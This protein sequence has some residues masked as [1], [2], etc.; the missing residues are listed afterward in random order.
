MVNIQFKFLFIFFFIGKPVDWWALGIILYEFLIGVVP[1]MGETPEELFSNI[2]NEEV[3]YPENDE[4][5]DPNAE[6][7]IRL[8]LE[9]NPMNRLGTV[10]DAAEVAAHSFFS[11]LDFNS[12]LRQKAEFVPQLENEEDTSYFDSREDRYNHD[13]ES[14]EDENVPMFWSF[15]TASPRH[16]I[17]E[18]ETSNSEL[19]DLQKTD[20]SSEAV[21]NNND[22]TES[23]LI[24]KSFS[25]ENN[26]LSINSAF[27]AVNSQPSV[28]SNLNDAKN[29]E[30]CLS[31]ETSTT[32]SNDLQPIPSVFF[33]FFVN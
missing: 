12:L 18:L 29:C 19:S 31:N 21:T 27:T 11:Q 7:L 24:N 1:F 9:K 16:S 2:I 17:V 33:F 15:S 10:G 25:I 23:K 4:A 14:R 6:S 28:I 5:L 30:N 3:E 20:D 13:A 8:L 26:T 22:N 32:K